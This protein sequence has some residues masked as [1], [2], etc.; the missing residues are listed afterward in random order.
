MVDILYLLV[1][2]EIFLGLYSLWE[3]ARWLRLARRRLATHPGFYAPRVALVCPCKGVEP[4]LEQNI[5]ALLDFDYSSYE[6]FFTLVSAT[7]P[8]HDVLRRVVTQSKPGSHSGMQKAHIVIAGP[9]EGCGE[10]VNNLR[11][12]VEQIPQEVEVLVF[13]DSDG[14]PARDWLKR[15]VAPLADA[16]LGAATTFRWYLPDRGG[17]WSAL[18]AAWNAAIATMLGEHAHN[19]C[20]GG[21][22]AIRR[23]VFDEVGALEFWRG[24]VSDD[25]SLTRALRRAGRPIHFVPECLVP[26]LQDADFRSL[27][28]FTNR[29]I[30]ITRVYAPRL[31]GLGAGSHVLYS[32]TLLLGVGVL[33]ALW[34]AGTLALHI[35]LL[36]LVVP[37]LAAA[38]GYLRLVAAIELL[39]AWKR[40]LLDY[41]WAWTLLAAL[42]PFL[43]LWNSLVAAFTRRILWRDIRYELISPN[44]TR[45]L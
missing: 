30:I 37:L 11:A 17:F 36:L 9:P 40:K 31:W 29:Q 16:R 28:E 14:R 6:V 44:Q 35:L 41:G 26:T 24:S 5:A 21:G 7:D 33:L 8:A 13:A 15:L 32:A 34:L 38:K 27:V 43:F 4:G 2:L 10:K 18:A 25:L 23:K 45:V 20:W 3:G 12:A 1:A 39:P 19:F 42:V 22:T